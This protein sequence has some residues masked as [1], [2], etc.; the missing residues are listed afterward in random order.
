MH[1]SIRDFVQESLSRYGL[2]GGVV[3]DVGSRDVNGNV[4]SLFDISSWTYIGVDMLPGPNVDT[5]VPLGEERYVLRSI[6]ERLGKDAADLVLYL[7]TAEHDPYPWK[8]TREIAKALK[9]GGFLFMTARGIYFPR[10]DHPCDYWRFTDDGI[11]LLIARAGLTLREIHPDPM[12][13]HPGWLAVAC[14]ITTLVS[15]DVR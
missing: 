9:P 5:V 2:S 13:R 15:D 4:R 14:R 12:P 7:E 1:P 11:R 6:L 8:T 10:H 3:L